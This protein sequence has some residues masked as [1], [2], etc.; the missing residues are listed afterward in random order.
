MNGTLNKK[1][2][3]TPFTKMDD[4]ISEM[5]QQ[6]VEDEVNMGRKMLVLIAAIVTPL[7]VGAFSAFLTMGDMNVYE[8]WSRPFLAPPSTVF[9]IVWIILYVI[10]GIA[11]YIIYISDADPAEKRK[12]LRLYAIQLGMNFFWSTLFFTYGQYMLSI[13]WLQAMWVVTLFCIVRFYNIR[14]IAGF[15]MVVPLLWM[16]FA[17]YLTIAYFTM[18]VTPMPL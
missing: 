9:P 3:K 14:K 13:L 10:M 4:K 18:S 2:D 6:S 7:L 5:L 8:I 11:S 16:S 1:M 17:T 15:M 12:A